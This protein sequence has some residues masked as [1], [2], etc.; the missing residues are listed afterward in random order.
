MAEYLI[1]GETL[2]AIGDAIRAQDGSTALIPP[3][4]MPAKIAA[5]ET[6]GGGKTYSYYDDVCFYDYDGTLVYSCTLVDAQTMTAL[7]EAPDH[8]NDPVPLT[9]LYWNYTLEEVN[10]LNRKADI[11]AI[12]KAT[13]GKTHFTL[14]LTELRGLTVPLNLCAYNAYPL[15]VDWGDGSAVEESAVTSGTRSMEHTYAQPGTYHVTCWI[16][17]GGSWVPGGTSSL[18]LCGKE[19]KNI[20]VVGT[21]V[22]GDD[23]TFSWPSSVG[24]CC[25]YNSNIEYLVYPYSGAWAGASRFERMPR[26]KFLA[27]KP[28]STEYSYRFVNECVSLKGISIPDNVVAAGDYGFSSLYSIRRICL[29]ASFTAT[30]SIAQR[31]MFAET[32]LHEIRLNEGQTKISMRDFQ[33]VYTLFSLTIPSTV[34]GIN[35]EAFDSSAILDFYLLPTT[36]PTLSNTNAFGNN[37]WGTQYKIHVPA[38]SLEAYQTATNWSTFA[39]KMVGDIT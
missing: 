1:Q 9:F 37:S 16:A 35:S 34:T 19:D 32:P 31:F 3:G 17:E 5:I 10:G 4:D 23:V 18:G 14:E 29:P 30:S 13:D 33:D 25:F 21:F 24:S 12:F 36:P 20:C 7:P 39:D 38:E 11:G 8:S 22:L 28:G 15:Y 27:V 6:G 26:L 2:T